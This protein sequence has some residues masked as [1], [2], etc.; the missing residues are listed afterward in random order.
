MN[1]K[2]SETYI[3]K[4][5]IYSYTVYKRTY[6]LII[7]EANFTT[8]KNHRSLCKERRKET[9]TDG[10]IWWWRLHEIIY[11]WRAAVVCAEDVK[12]LCL[13]LESKSANGEHWPRAAMSQQD[14]GVLVTASRGAA[15][16]LPLLICTAAPPMGRQT[17]KLLVPLYCERPGA[18]WH[19]SA[20]RWAAIRT[21]PRWLPV[22]RAAVTHAD[23]GVGGGR[24]FHFLFLFLR[25]SHR[26]LCFEPV[27]HAFLPF[28]IFKDLC[29]NNYTSGCRLNSLSLLNVKV[30]TPEFET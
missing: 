6:I 8:K 19:H 17:L 10:S 28:H 12:C 13:Q 26:W 11:K 22:Q 4:T 29:V 3:C 7:S 2:E 15:S 18:I 9:Q 16:L 14:R 24:R 20:V 5:N 21:R 27:C 23:G 30:Q 25:Q 1:L